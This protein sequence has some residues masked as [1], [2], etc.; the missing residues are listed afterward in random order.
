MANDINLASGKTIGNKGVSLPNDAIFYLAND[1]IKARL[2]I[3]N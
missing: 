2:I 3:V 1:T